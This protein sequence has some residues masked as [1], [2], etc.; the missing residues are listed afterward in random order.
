MFEDR[1]D[2]RT[3]FVHG[4]SLIVTKY[5]IDATV[6]WLVLGRIWTPLDYLAAG[7]SITSAR[8]AGTPRWLLVAMALWTLPFLWIGIS[9]TVRRAIDAGRSPWLSLLFFVPWVNYVFMLVLS[10]LPARAPAKGRLERPRRHEQRLPSALLAIAG[11]L[12]FGLALPAL[13]IFGFQRYGVMLFVATPFVVGAVTAWVFNLLY[14][15]SWRET[16]EVVTLT[17]AFIGGTLILIAIEGAVCVAMAAPIAIAGALMGAVVGR[18]IA[19]RDT[20]EPREL[21]L[22]LLILPGGMALES[23]TAEPELR[24]VLTS[25]EIDAPPEVVWRRV[26]EFPPLETPTE[27]PFRLGIAYPMSAR[28]DGTGVGAT[29]HC[30]F[31]T[32]SFIEPITRWETNRVLGFDVVDQ[33]APLAEWSP[34][35]RI[36]PPH[37]DG[38][39]K[40]RRGEFRLIPLPGNRT[41]LEGRTW[42]EL[43]LQPA[44]YWMLW[45]DALIGRIHS[46]VL[47]HIRAL[48]EMDSASTEGRPLGDGLPASGMITRPI[49]TSGTATAP[50]GRW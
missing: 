7:V 34:Y 9:M 41:R 25:V 6:F 17:T 8:F 11:G 37:L 40:T 45:S 22:A 46:R 42:Y 33:P 24:E 26:I 18:W 10:M 39:L 3:Y 20:S 12:A 30:V 36:A 15:S 4:L 49:A 5:L 29:R 32:G 48:A 31:S 13:S 44:G 1:V 28:I 23:P 47:R 16:T 19:L 14:P 2:R 50:T 27:L 43:D 21:L 35:E 38:Y